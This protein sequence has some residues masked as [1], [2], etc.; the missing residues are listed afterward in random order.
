M[1]PPDAEHGY[2]KR[3]HDSL[4]QT[5]SEVGFTKKFNILKYSLVSA[6]TGYGIEDLITVNFLFFFFF[7]KIN[8]KNNFF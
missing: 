1:I 3:Y 4:K 5:I 6:K 7:I 8:K 2:L